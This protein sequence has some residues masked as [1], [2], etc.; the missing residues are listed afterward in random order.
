MPK[1][2]HQP[3]AD[4]SEF[5]PDI[6]SSVSLPEL[7]PRVLMVGTLLRIIFGASSLYLVLKVG[8][9]LAPDPHG[10]DLAQLTP[11]AVRTTLLP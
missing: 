9:R 8:L 3:E 2:K 5:H 11:L 6:P 7:T 4:K 10:R 1:P